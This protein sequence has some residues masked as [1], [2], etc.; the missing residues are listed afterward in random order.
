VPR[1]AYKGVVVFRYQTTRRI[2]LVGPESLKLLR[3]ED[4]DS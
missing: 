2:F 4:L 1:A 3:I